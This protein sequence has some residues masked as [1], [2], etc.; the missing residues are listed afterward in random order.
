M[1]HSL[2]FA[3]IIREAPSLLFDKSHLQ[4]LCQYAL[5]AAI[6]DLFG[7]LADTRFFL[8]CGVH[9]TLRPCSPYTVQLLTRKERS[10]LALFVVT[11]LFV[12]AFHEI[13][14]SLT[15]PLRNVVS[16]RYNLF[17]QVLGPY[18]TTCS[19]QHCRLSRSLDMTDIPAAS[20][21]LIFS[22][23]PRFLS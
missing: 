8:A 18:E 1:Q 7:Q 3:T 9:R 17:L 5:I 22:Q 13:I 21:A 4:H 10:L 6:H 12:C 20:V 14:V 15:A 23:T 11:L 2:T 19:Q 16:L